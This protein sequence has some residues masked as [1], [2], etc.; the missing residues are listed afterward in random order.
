M[1]KKLSTPSGLPGGA[2]SA[3]QAAWVS[4]VNVASSVPVSG[5]VLRIEFPL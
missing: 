5:S 1:S 4:I 2:K 3:G